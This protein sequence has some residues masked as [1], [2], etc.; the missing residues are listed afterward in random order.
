MQ[1]LAHH[2]FA[3]PAV[4]VFR[5]GI[6]EQDFAVHIAHHDGFGRQFQQF[7]ASA[8]LLFALAQFFGAFCHAPFQFVVQ[9]LEHARLAM[10]FDKDADL[11]AQHFGNYRN[12]DVVDRAAAIAL[13]LVG[14]G[15]VNAGDEDDRS[16]LKARMLP[17]HV[18]KFKSIEIGH[19]HVHQHHGDVGLQQDAERLAGGG[20]LD[21]ILAKFREDHLVAEQLGRLV[22]DHQDVDL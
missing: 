3:L 14:V 16:L 7:G 17:D 20:G 4:E 22:I 2:L 15:E 1:I 6:P 5:A 19:A 12:G 8:E 18:G 10:Q 11:G 13:D 9:H 21:E